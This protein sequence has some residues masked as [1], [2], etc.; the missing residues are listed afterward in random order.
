MNATASAAEVRPLYEHGCNQRPTYA[1]DLPGFGHA[2]RSHR[3]YTIRLMTDAVH[4]LVGWIAARHEGRPVDVLAV[5]LSVEF[6][7]RAAVEAPE[8]IRRLALVSP[9]GMN[10]K[11][12]RHGS[13]E[14]PRG[15]PWLRRALIDRRWSPGLYRILTRPG[16]VRYFLNGTWGS[17]AIDETMWRYGVRSTKE[18]GAEY[19]PLYFVCGALFAADSGTLYEALQQPVWVSH[20]I[21]GDFADYR[22]GALLQDRPNWR[23]DALPTG[24]LP[25]FEMRAEFNARLDAFLD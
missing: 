7:V 15:P 13:A 18:P 4:D 8:S 19:A 16:V 21:R 10:G 23:F 9:T 24:A 22:A 5:S 12:L 20:G 2:E 25:Y 6:A 17:K 11:Q 3:P 14:A 1:A